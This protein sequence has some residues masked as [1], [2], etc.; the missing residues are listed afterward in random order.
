MAQ[1]LVIF[2]IGYALGQQLR[3]LS[4][5]LLLFFLVF[6]IGVSF[7]LNREAKH[8]DRFIKKEEDK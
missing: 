3:W 8:G 2:L 4:Y 6:S 1:G 5:S 7:F